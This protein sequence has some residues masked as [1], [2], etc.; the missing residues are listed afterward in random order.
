MIHKDLLRG[1]GPS[2][3]YSVITYMGKESEKKIDTCMYISDSFAVRLKLTQ[4]CESALLR[5]EADISERRNFVLIFK[6]YF[7]LIEG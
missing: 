3:Y 2:T 7:L 6:I 4:Y 5:Y 1:V